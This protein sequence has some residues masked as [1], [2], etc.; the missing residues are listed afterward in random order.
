M[1]LKMHTLRVGTRDTA[2]KPAGKVAL[3]L[4]QIRQSFAGIEEKVGVRVA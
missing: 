1:K 3:A 2:M 4:I